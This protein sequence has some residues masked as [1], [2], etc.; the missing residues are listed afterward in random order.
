[1]KIRIPFFAL[2]LM[3]VFQMG[4]FVS[5]Y[6]GLVRLGLDSLGLGHMHVLWVQLLKML[7]IGTT[8]LSCGTLPE[9]PGFWMELHELRHSLMGN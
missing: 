1:M 9:S 7:L 8:M 3:T 2:I 4:V 5:D 6:P